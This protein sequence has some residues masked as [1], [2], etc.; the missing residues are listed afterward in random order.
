MDN[1]FNILIAGFGGQGVLFAGKVLAYCGLLDEKHISWL[2]SYGPEMRGGTANCSVCISNTPVGS[3]LVLN[4]NVFVAMNPPSFDKFINDVD[5]GA[6]VFIDS[7][8]IIRKVERDDLKVFYVPATKLALE[9]N[10]KGL[11]NMIIL[12][13]MF[14]ELKFCSYE[15][16]SSAI[17]KCIPPKKS[18]LL[19][20]NTK[21]I[22]LGIN[23]N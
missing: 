5:P 21:A 23:L 22:D 9:N 6:Y 11:A 7:S 3:P 10:L 13:K 19:E 16:L 14:S 1:N 18:H 20:F 4:P 17:K 2:P 15:T 12:G 8:L